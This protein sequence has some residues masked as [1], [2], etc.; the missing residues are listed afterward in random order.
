MTFE[1]DAVIGELM[2][3]VFQDAEFTQVSDGPD[4]E[5]YDFIDPAGLGGYVSI[6]VICTNVAITAVDWRSRRDRRLAG[7]SSLRW[8]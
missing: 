8:W 3:V 4:Q 5:A 7:P 2:A 1:P 6:T